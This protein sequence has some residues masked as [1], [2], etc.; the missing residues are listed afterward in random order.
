MVAL[1]SEAVSALKEPE[2][3]GSVRLGVLDDYAASYLPPVLAA[4][5]AGLAVAAL[6]V[7]AVPADALVL[8]ASHG[9]PELPV[10]SILLSLAAD[11][12]PEPVRRLAAAVGSA[13]SEGT[14]RI[15][16]RW[17]GIMA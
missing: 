2:M 4:V 13:L 10:D 8:G 6:G 1:H 7:S 11:P 14:A 3:S 5:K 9:F 16:S 17:A 12:P 15:R